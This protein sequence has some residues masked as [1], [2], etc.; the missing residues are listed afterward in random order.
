M[1]C[2]VKLPDGSVCGYVPSGATSK[3]KVTDLYRHQ[4]SHVEAMN[5]KA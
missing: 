2:R 3:E 4:Q 1:T 5:A